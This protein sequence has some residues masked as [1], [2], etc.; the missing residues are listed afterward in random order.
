MPRRKS[1]PLPPS[2][3]LLEK[4]RRRVEMAAIR[5]EKDA[6]KEALKE[7]V[8]KNRC[9]KEASAREAA[10]R[11]IKKAEDAI[12]KEKQEKISLREALIEEDKRLLA[13]QNALAKEAVEKQREAYLAAEKQ[14][15]KDSEIFNHHNLITDKDLTYIYEDFLRAVPEKS[16]QVN[17]IMNEE[18]TE[19]DYAGKE[20]T[21]VPP[22]LAYLFSYR[23][24]RLKRYINALKKFQSDEV[25]CNSYYNFPTYVD[26]TVEK[27]Y[28]LYKLAD[29]KVIFRYQR[30]YGQYTA[31]S[32]IYHYYF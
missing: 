29:G 3:V 5:A 21:S 4:E 16:I 11:D 13:E 23:S 8:R 14:R 15:R 10:S 28:T 25:K 20:N 30:F 27:T 6:K 26:P 9:A 7:A 1:L 12:F 31:E 2:P 18:F 24:Y 17:E 32:P 19:E 22:S